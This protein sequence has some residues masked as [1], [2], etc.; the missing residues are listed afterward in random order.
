MEVRTNAARQIQHTTDMQGN[1][2][3]MLKTL[4]QASEDKAG[5]AQPPAG[6]T[7]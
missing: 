2:M 4:R 1:D 5:K 6:N 3:H 7:L